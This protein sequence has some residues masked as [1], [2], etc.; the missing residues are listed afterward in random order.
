MRWTS[1]FVVPTFAVA[2]IGRAGALAAAAALV[3]AAVACG[4]GGPKPPRHVVL[5]TVDTLRADHLGAY[6]YRPPTSPFLDGLAREATVFE[7]AI[8]TAPSTAPSV[9]SLLSGLHRASHGVWSNGGTLPERVTTLA[10][11]L[12]AHGFHTAARIANPLLDA[13][14]G[15]AQGFDDFAMPPG[16]SHKPPAVLEGTHVVEAVRRLLDGLGDTRLFLWLHFYDPHG[17]YYPPDTYRAAFHPDDYR[18]PED[19]D[20]PRAEGHSGL[21]LIPRYQWI[22]DSTAPSVYRARY[23]AEIRYADDHV[24]AIVELLQT[25]RLWDETLFVL[26]ADHGEALGEHGFFFQ[27]GWF[28]YDDCLHVPLV[29][30]APGVVP[31]GRRVAQTVS[32][33]DV[34]PT[35][36]DLVGIA[37]PDDVEG[38]TLRPFLAGEAA[39]R[40]AFAQSYQGTGSVALRLGSVKYI[41][42]PGRGPAAPPP[43]A[44]DEAILPA[45]AQ[46][47]LYDVAA[48]RA[49]AHDLA[50]TRPDLLTALRGRVH[51]W[52]VDQHRRGER[53]VRGGPAEAGSPPTGSTPLDPVVENQLRALGYL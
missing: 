10:E 14:V 31:R 44:G 3:A 52:L 17:P 27:H 39:D 4:L 37:P 2:R 7:Q 12:R 21:F 53:Q 19:R 20:L 29:L 18:W 32:L 49:E 48:D 15:F 34:T 13:R 11:I 42:R 9:A 8:A 45:E 24:R 26:T 35:I 43:A 38:Q 36:L 33:I 30:R 41:F 6:G 51:A 46:H 47:E 28:S 1:C 23:D 25:H 50:A 5:V 22:D 16:L 40:P